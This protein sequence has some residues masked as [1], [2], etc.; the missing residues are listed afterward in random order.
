MHYIHLLTLKGMHNIKCLLKPISP[1]AL[2]PSH[3]ELLGDVLDN[4][5]GLGVLP[6]VHLLHLVHLVTAH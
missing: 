3:L 2:C 4:L 1:P 6:Q 5:D